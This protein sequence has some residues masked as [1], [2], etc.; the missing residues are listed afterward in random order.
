MNDN[1]QDRFEAE[2]MAELEE[3]MSQ[4]EYKSFE[5]MF[6][7]IFGEENACSTEAE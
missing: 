4:P 7:Q 3:A 5:F 6:N 2:V 1:D